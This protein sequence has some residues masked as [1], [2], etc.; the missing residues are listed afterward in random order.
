ME[1]KQAIPLIMIYFPLN[2]VIKPIQDTTQLLVSFFPCTNSSFSIKYCVL[3]ISNDG[4][5][6]VAYILK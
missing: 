1:K 4:S 2:Y 6:L 3:Y 5:G